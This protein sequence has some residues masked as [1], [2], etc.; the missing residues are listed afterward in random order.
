MF[1][2]R[3]A[4]LALSALSLVSAQSDSNSTFKIDPSEVTP[5]QQSNW[6]NAQQNSCSTLCGSVLQNNC[7][8]SSLNFLCECEGQSYPD[9]NKFENTIPWFVC[10]QLQDDCTAQNA[11]NAAGQKNCTATYGSKCGTED[12]N[13]HQGEG[14]ATTSTSSS[15]TSTTAKST[16]TAEPTTSSSSGAASVPTAHVQHFG[17]GAA[18]VALGLLAYAL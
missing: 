13:D 3:V 12:V 4:L 8:P 14:A 18:A 11:G 16:S 9:M 15:A 2:D 17:N 7:D 1:T 10:T 6:C 5:L